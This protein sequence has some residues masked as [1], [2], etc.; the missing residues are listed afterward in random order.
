[1][2]DLGLDII[3]HEVL[4]KET[5]ERTQL[6]KVD[7]RDTAFSQEMLQMDKLP[8]DIATPTSCTTRATWADNEW[9]AN[10]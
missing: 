4:P 10:Y 2:I 3:L 1:M 8:A 5:K 9:V 6:R 7:L